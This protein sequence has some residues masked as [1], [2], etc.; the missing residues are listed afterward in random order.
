MSSSRV[1]VVGPGAIGGAV[2]AALFEA[3]H[4]PTICARTAFDRLVVEHAGGVIDRPVSVATDPATVAPVD[5]VFIAVKAHH[6]A[7]AKPWLDAIAGSGSTVVV[8]QNG[9]EHRSRFAPLVRPGVNVVPC[10]INL[11][12]R[13][14]EP[15]RIAVGKVARLTLER[16]PGALPAATL[17]DG[18]YV[19]CD[20]AED[21]L[22]AAWTKLM[23]NAASGGVCTL[24]RTDNLIFGD[25]E[26][27]DIA[28]AIM[29]EVASVG[30][31]EGAYLAD[32]LP[33]RIIDGLVTSASGHLAS[34]VA[35][36]IAG[37]PTE[38]DIRNAVVARLAERHGIDVPLNRLL[39]TLIRLGEPAASA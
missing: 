37:N 9:V 29:S 31:A 38:W 23:L 2:A 34:I 33:E 30:R 32:D 22:T 36:R 6:S 15:G 1:A 7:A 26:A 16:L 20:V 39:T 3:G 4:E 28:V 24:T 14:S 25:R 13:R 17:F 18:S 11:P 19:T 35:D 8:L 27:R 10:V 5:V 12:G 21:W